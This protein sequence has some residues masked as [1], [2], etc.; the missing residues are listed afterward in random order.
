MGL[1]LFRFTALLKEQAAATDVDLKQFG[2]PNG[3]FAKI[4]TNVHKGELAAAGA[5]RIP[6]SLDFFVEQF[7]HIETFKN[8]PEVVGIGKLSDPPTEADLAKV[9][10]GN[11][12]EETLAGCRP[13]KCG[14]KLSDEMIT[15]LHAAASHGGATQMEAEFHKILLDF[16]T[17]YMAQ[18]TLAMIAYHDMTPAVETGRRFQ[19]LLA[20]Y[21]WLERLAPKMYQ[22]LRQSDPPP[23]GD[24]NQFIYWSKESFGLKP[25]LSLTHIVIGRA[26]IDG[27]RWAFIASKQIFADHYFEASLG[28]TIIHEESA[29]PNPMI[30]LAYFNRSMTDGLKGWF[31]S[32]QRSII[33][34]KVRG[35]VG[36]NLTQMR[37]R[38][39]KSYS[40]RGR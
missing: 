7:R 30:S 25:V 26:T 38:L 27:S 2:D 9:T 18:G 32:L 23:H 14:V 35:A 34:R 40:I 13:G 6:V 36:K 37:D 29:G 10:L 16:L 5:V 31:A 4:L 8:E 3:V 28:L 17:R 20:E 39:K 15:R 33:E 12:D 19:E 21:G 24:P 11:K 1:R 22:T